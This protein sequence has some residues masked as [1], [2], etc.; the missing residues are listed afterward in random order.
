M[1]MLAT[2]QGDG[3]V[4]VRI[5]PVVTMKDRDGKP[6]HFRVQEIETRVLAQHGERTFIGGADT[7]NSEF[8]RQLLGPDVYSK[9][10]S[11]SAMSMYLTPYVRLMDRA[12]PVDRAS[13]GP[14]RYRPARPR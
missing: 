2:Y 1:W 8:L 6:H 4:D 13:D 7:A 3:V 10:E 5:F 11:S 14:D 9:E 12:A